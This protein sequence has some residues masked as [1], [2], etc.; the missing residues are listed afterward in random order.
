MFGPVG[1]DEAHEASF[2]NTYKRKA[3]RFGGLVRRF[4]G[5][6]ARLGDPAVRLGGSSG[7]SVRWFGGLDRWFG[8]VVRF[9]GSAGWLGLVEGWFGSV[10]RS[11]AFV[12]L[13]IV[14]VR[15]SPQQDREKNKAD[16]RTVL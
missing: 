16:F 8:A 10:V 4:G 7:G 15:P 14:C 2:V 11:S 3:A 6:S 1:L 13:W 5:P 12:K 9:G